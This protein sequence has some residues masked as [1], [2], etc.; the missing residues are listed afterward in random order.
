LTNTE[1][2][3]CRVGEHRVGVPRAHID[4]LLE[5]TGQTALPGTHGWVA[6]VALIR[7]QLTLLVALDSST[8]PRT[9]VLRLAATASRQG[10][11]RI[12]ILVDANDAFETLHPEPTTVPS[13]LQF[14]KAC[15]DQHAK[16]AWLLDVDKIL[17]ATG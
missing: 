8:A 10:I 9:K 3:V 11:E 14:A 17:Q 4:E 2:L 5:V 13:P 15:V 1:C 7:N 16:R 6:G 12:G